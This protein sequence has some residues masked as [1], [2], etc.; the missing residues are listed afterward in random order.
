[1][2][3]P[4]QGPAAHGSAREAPRQGTHFT[5]FTSTKA[6]MLTGEEVLRRLRQATCSPSSAP[7]RCCRRS[8]YVSA[9]YCIC[10][11]MLLYVCSHTGLVGGPSLLLALSLPAF[12]CPPT[13]LCSHTS[14]YIYRPLTTIYVSSYYDV[15]LYMCQRRCCRRSLCRHIPLYLCCRTTMCVCPHTSTRVC[16]HYARARRVAAAG[17][18]GQERGATR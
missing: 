13:T 1:V 11:L 6:Q 4:P 8:I 10:V 7:R 2:P 12:M 9:Y 17:A 3:V 15:L 14:I 16:S 18:E 5:C